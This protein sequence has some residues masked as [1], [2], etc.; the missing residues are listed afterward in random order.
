METS[1]V[2]TAQCERSAS[3]LGWPYFSQSHPLTLKMKIRVMKWW[4]YNDSPSAFTIPGTSVI[5]TIKQASMH[6]ILFGGDQ[7]T[8]VRGRGAKKSRV[9]FDSP[10]SI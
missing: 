10:V 2:K 4:I 9:N 8:T 1:N 3:K 6:S 5:A 7:L